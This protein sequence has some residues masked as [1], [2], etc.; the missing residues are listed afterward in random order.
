MKTSSAK[1]IFLDRSSTL[2][3]TLLDGPT[4]SLLVSILPHTDPHNT[5]AR[6][7]RNGLAITAFVIL[8]DFLKTRI[9][10]IFEGIKFHSVPFASLYDEIKVATTLNAIDSIKSRAI[11]LK[12]SGKDWLTFIQQETHKIS[13]TSTSRYRLSNYSLGWDKSNVRS[14]DISLWLKIL[15]IEGGWQTIQKITSKA[16]VT[17][18][19]PESIYQAAIERRHSAAHDPASDALYTDLT[20]FTND[21]K[22]ISLAF[23]TLVTK[24]LTEINKPNL[25]L[26]SGNKKISDSD[27]DFRFIINDGI[28]WRE[29]KNTSR[30]ALKRSKSLNLAIKEAKKR[31]KPKG[32]I[33]VIKNN[34]NSIVDWLYMD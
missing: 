23:D 10:E 2:S 4:S 9:G 26:L 31:A 6:I 29:Y 14:D 17:L 8:E 7:L 15:R 22:A 18:V 19:S 13:S 1:K 11:Y 28:Y 25:L 20:Q 16:E 27:I 33:L 3:S 30:R 32:E 34:L 24:V 12:R 21:A 5:K